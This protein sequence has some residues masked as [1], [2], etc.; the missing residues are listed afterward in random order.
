MLERFFGFLQKHRQ[1]ARLFATVAYSI[2][3]STVTFSIL[4]ATLGVG[5]ATIL[6]FLICGVISSVP[7]LILWTF[8][9]TGGEE[10]HT[11]TVAEL[12]EHSHTLDAVSPTFNYA[13]GSMPF[14]QYAPGYPF[15]STNATGGDTAHNNVPP[16]TVLCAM[17]QAL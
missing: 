8:G 3:L 10:D 12:P 16:Y 13:P 6:P 5:L 17:I 9:D 4:W 11:L 1:L 15:M 14:Y 2:L 7:V